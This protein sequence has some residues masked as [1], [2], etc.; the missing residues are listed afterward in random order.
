MV[1]KVIRPNCRIQFTPAD[2]DFMGTVL[3]APGRDFNRLLRLCEDPQDMDRILDNPKLYQA[4][5]EL[6]SCLSVSLHFYFY[7]LVRQVLLREA[8]D[9]REVADYVAEVLAEFSGPMRWRQPDPAAPPMEYLYEMM[10]SLEY[11]DPEYRFT[12]LTHI[13][14]YALFLSGIFPRRL[15]RRLERRA[16]PGFRFYEE[17]GSAHFRIA[18]GHYLAREMDLAPVLMD[19]GEAFHLA[20][21]ALNHLSERLVFLQTNRAVEDLF[22]EIDAQA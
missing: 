16:A 4:V 8:V 3:S 17:M 21:L 15:A 2:Y 7:V 10:A 19:L 18:G 20:R 12:M 1:M 11:A 5:L 14:N 22:R 6:K 13:G 9:S